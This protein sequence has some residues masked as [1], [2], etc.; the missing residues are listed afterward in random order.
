[1]ALRPRR[2]EMGDLLK[3]RSFGVI[4]STLMYIFIICQC[5]SCIMDYNTEKRLITPKNPTFNVVKTLSESRNL[6]GGYYIHWSCINCFSTRNSNTLLKKS[7]FLC[8]SV[9]TDNNILFCV[10]LHVFFNER[11]FQ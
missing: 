7:G 1:M 10:F 11:K 6:P 9:K 2:R 3:V 4:L 8:D 5:A